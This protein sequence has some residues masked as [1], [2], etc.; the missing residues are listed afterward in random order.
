[1]N[2][3][4]IFLKYPT[5]GK[6]K[7]RIAKDTDINTASD[8][9]KSLVH[10]TI[11]NLPISSNLTWRFVFDP[12]EKKEHIIKWLKPSIE[13]N[14][15]SYEQTQDY[16]PVKNFK[17]EYYPQS[18]GDLGNRLEH[19]F[20]QTFTENETCKVAVIGTDCID[21]TPLIF[22]QTWKALNIKDLVLGPTNDGGYYLLALKNTQPQIF[23]N[24]PWSSENTLSKTIE[25]ASALDLKIQLLDKFTDID[26]Y[27]TWQ[28]KLL[29]S[30][31][32]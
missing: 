30:G 2:I 26:N 31:N 14:I 8:I 1:M 25:K 20:D 11:Q 12:P 15:K 28:E 21:I 9:Y 18:H 22:E 7:T 6:V 4:L 16:K 13:Q 5:P 24:I 32:C 27:S 10:K 19:A 23:Q 29:T 3:I 17:I